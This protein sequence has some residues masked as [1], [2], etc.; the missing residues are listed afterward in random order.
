MTPLDRA[1]AYLASTPGAIA[2]Q[3]G[4]NHTFAVCCAVIHGFDLS[5]SE[6]SI[7]VDEW[8]RKCDP[9]WSEAELDHK[10]SEAYG[11]T[12]IKGRPRGYLL[13]E[14]QPVRKLVAKK[15]ELNPPRTQPTFNVDNWRVETIANQGSEILAGLSDRSID[16]IKACSPFP[17]P[18]GPDE[19]FESYLSIWG[20]EKNNIWIG[21]VEDSGSP[22]MLTYF[23]PPSRWANRGNPNGNKLWTAGC[24][25]AKGAFSRSKEN[26]VEQRFVIAE[27]DRYDYSRQ[28]AIFF[29]LKE[30]LKLPIKM[31]VNTMGVSLHIWID[32][33]NLSKEYVA[34]LQTLL[35]GLHN[36]LEEIEG[37]KRRKYRGGMGCD[38][39]TFRGSQPARLPG[40]ERPA[41]PQN[42]KQGGLQHIIYL[43]LK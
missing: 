38:P 4:H 8:N 1:R 36:G 19:N 16:D 40:G 24:S 11:S 28:A 42:G 3:G 6:A 29:F 30:T 37:K 22:A 2:G 34:N 41:D 20:E 25:F 27:S 32:I 26:I 35:C 13:R 31:V 17:L 21:H 15:P 33:T 5:E 9:E 14:N 43:D 12:D 18:Q 7:A 10:I 23:Q 39:A